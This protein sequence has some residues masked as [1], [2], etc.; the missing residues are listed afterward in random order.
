MSDTYKKDIQ[1]ERR[2]FKICC[3]FDEWKCSASH[4]DRAFVGMKIRGGMPEIYF[5]MGYSQ[6]GKKIYDDPEKFDSEMKDDFY[7]LV[8]ILSDEA[9]PSY[10][11]KDE[12]QKCKLDFPLHAFWGVIRYYQNHGYF[13]ETDVIYKKG[14]PGK[15]NWSKTIKNIRPDVAKN[16]NGQYSVF[17]LNLVARKNFYRENNLITEIHKFCI[18][19][20]VRLVGVFLGIS[21]NDIEPSIYNNDLENI[22]DYD[23]FIDVVREKMESTFNDRFIDLFSHML[24]VL[25]FL[26]NK[27]VEGDEDSQYMFGVEGFAHVWEMMVDRIF[28]TLSSKEINECNPHLQFVLD[29]KDDLGES[30]RSTLRPDT[31]MICD[32][33]NGRPGCFVLDSKFYKF[34]L[35]SD[36]KKERIKYLPGADSTCKQM[37][38]A[39]Y[40]KEKKGISFF[41]KIKSNS[42]YNAFIMPYCAAIKKNGKLEKNKRKCSNYYGI[43]SKGYMYGDWK[44]KW[45][46]KHPYFRIACILLDVKSVMRD[47]N[48]SFKAQNILAKQIISAINPKKGT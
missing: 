48:P 41:S 2:K 33:E 35:Y 1:E 38:Y 28:G 29:S 12:M 11:A 9:L 18:Y 23:F 5:P 14:G 22:P 19:E 3:V 46:D 8:R 47:Y 42:I 15:I 40:I 17:Y 7:C 10:F 36:D 37:A 21:V 13:Y 44:N 24:Q 16:G 25:K 6:E 31:I 26:S 20:A 32:V 39:E 30:R 34:G 43:K 4:E 45:D 27:Q